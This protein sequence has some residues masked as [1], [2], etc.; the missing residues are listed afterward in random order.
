ML[1]ACRGDDSTS[2]QTSDT[3]DTSD[4]SG[5]A[6]SA[7]TGETNDTADSI[8]TSSGVSGDTSDSDEPLPECDLLTPYR[9]CTA[10]TNGYH[11]VKTWDADG[12]IASDDHY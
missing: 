10:D 6:D 7:D 1:L 5:S 9:G 3:S 11:S 2:T 4:T 12:R 8:D